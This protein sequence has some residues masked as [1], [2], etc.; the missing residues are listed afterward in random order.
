LA[1]AEP[2]EILDQLLPILALTAGVGMSQDDRT[3]WLGA[4]VDALKDI[5]GDLLKASIIRAR[6]NC[7]HP[8]KVIPFI[9]KDTAE[10]WNWR[11]KHLADVRETAQR[12]TA[13]PAPDQSYC[14]AEEAAAIVNE[15]FPQARELAPVKSA[16]VPTAADYIA[17]GHSPESAAKIMG[18]YHKPD[19][20][21]IGQ[22]VSKATEWPA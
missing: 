5:P 12:H 4:A 9:T 7:D 2:E 17:L 15:V 13:L 8:S 11:R 10:S 3:E 21:Q 16:H 14:T 6:M 20:K 1:P 19:A 22:L 18:Q